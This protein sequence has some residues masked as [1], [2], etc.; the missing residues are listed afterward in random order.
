MVAV[1]I[2][3]RSLP[4]TDHRIE[5]DGRSRLSRVRVVEASQNVPWICEYTQ[6]RSHDVAHR[7]AAHRRHSPIGLRDRHVHEFGATPE[8]W[9]YHIVVKAT[10]SMPSAGALHAQDVIAVVVWLTSPIPVP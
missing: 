9:S 3:S 7:V 8:S 4:R 1:G 10:A 2:S 5:L 6:P